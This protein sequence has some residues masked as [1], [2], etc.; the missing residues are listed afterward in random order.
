MASISLQERELVSRQN[1]LH[2][3]FAPLRRGKDRLAMGF[4]NNSAGGTKILVAREQP[5]SSRPYRDESFRTSATALRCS[6]FELW[7]VA[8]SNSLVLDRAYFTLLRVKQAS[9]A[10][11]EILCLHTDPGDHEEFK[12]GPH[13][14]VSCAEHPIPHCH[15]P[16]DLGSLAVVLKN[17]EALTDAMERA[18]RVIAE[19]VLPRF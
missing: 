3:I 10:F 18:I 5:I 12:Q 13:L 9:T 6:Y 1:S 16:L 17:C 7:R 19:D 11:D 4:A 14:H 8:P 15:F 2:K